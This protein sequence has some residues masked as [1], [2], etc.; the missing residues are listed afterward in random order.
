M[1]CSVHRACA[2]GR[3]TP[4]D[5][6]GGSLSAVS[7]AKPDAAAR[8]DERLP[9]VTVIVPTF[10]R[11]R[12]LSQTIE[13]V[14]AQDSRDFTLMVADNAS[15]D[16]TAEVVGGYQDPRIHYLRRP[17]NIGW[18]RNF[19]DALGA[20]RTRF[21]TVLND[22]DLMM[23]GALTRAL[24][25]L[26]PNP[27]VGM[28]H[29]AHDSIGPDGAVLERGSSWSHGL[30]RDTIEP[31]RTFLR[32][33]MKYYE[34][35]CPPSVVFRTEALPATPYEPR[36]EPHAVS[37]LYLRIA[38][39]WDIG[40]LAASGVAWRVHGDQ[41]SSSMAHVVSD[42]AMARHTETITQMRDV[43]LRFIDE[44]ADELSHV[45]GLRRRVAD[46]VDAELVAQ[47][48]TEFVDGR[49]AVAR[50]LAS[51]V[52]TSPTVLARPETWRLVVRT[53]VGPRGVRMYH[54]I[55]P[56]RSA[57][58]VSVGSPAE[59]SVDDREVRDGDDEAPSP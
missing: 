56:D 44:H 15:V 37:V 55:R 46:F 9:P 2:L 12:Y 45:G 14:L 49:A 20:I 38:L 39:S 33:A 43:R 27:D 23:P 52:R 34:L 18:L 5:G 1:L 48:R 26:E 29:A 58:G 7:D 51:K 24:G 19:N 30:V 47:A 4:D 59:S 13:S 54:Q 21:V 22:D 40:Y 3:G 35:V 10:N 42:G 16:D 36:D 25:M 53:V 41:D 32:R 28:V 8:T 31:G 11:S 50:S 6:H 57:T 17:E